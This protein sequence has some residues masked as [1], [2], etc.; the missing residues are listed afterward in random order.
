MWWLAPIPFLLHALGMLVDEV[1]FHRRRGL[2]AWERWGHPLD[3]FTVLVCYGLLV[4]LPP[5]RNVLWVYVIA[6][7]F[8]SLFITKDE[9]I[10]A[11]YCQG[12]E[13]WLHAVLFIA[14]PVLLGIAGIWRFVPLAT[15]DPGH[16]FFSLFFHGQTVL[17]AVFLFYQLLYW[18]GPWKPAEKI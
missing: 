1:W 6:A 9:W 15:P 8:S 17:T 7:I 5:T 4:S 10:H 14:H 13:L 2:P 16:V 18:N 11:R 12:G 3:T